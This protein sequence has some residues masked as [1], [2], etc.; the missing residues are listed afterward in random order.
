MEKRFYEMPELEVINLQ[1]EGQILS[2]SITDEIID[3]A[4]GDT[5]NTGG[6]ADDS[7]L[8]D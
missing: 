6:S 7:G 5:D 2:G 8:G 3:N 1:I 4:A